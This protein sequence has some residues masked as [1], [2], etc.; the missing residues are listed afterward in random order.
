[1]WQYQGKTE[2]DHEVSRSENQS[3]RLWHKLAVVVPKVIG[4]LG[5]ISK[6]LE[7]HCT[8]TKLP[9]QLQKAKLL[10]F[11]HILG[12][13]NILGFREE[14]DSKESQHQLKNWQLLF[15]VVVYLIIVITIVYASKIIVLRPSTVFSTIWFLTKSVRIMEVSS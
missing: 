5:T 15:H 12:W 7:W 2:V 9:C 11:T 4:T 1:M 8:L 10:G 3:E 13:Y 14:L 6:I